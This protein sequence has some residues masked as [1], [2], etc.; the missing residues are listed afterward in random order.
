MP[1]VTPT[2]MDEFLEREGITPQE[3]FERLGQTRITFWVRYW[4]EE[5]ALE[6]WSKFW[7]LVE[8]GIVEEAPK[9]EVEKVQ[10]AKEF[11]REAGKEE[12]EE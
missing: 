3:Y 10:K 4:G 12:E 6:E 11:M 7:E 2:W 5:K 8:L 9:Y 1:K